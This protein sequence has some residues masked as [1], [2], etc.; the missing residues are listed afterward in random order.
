VEINSAQPVLSEIISNDQEKTKIELRRKKV[1]QASQK[2]MF[3]REKKS[4]F[5]T[6]VVAGI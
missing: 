4:K 1:T 5:V 6:S 2:N 3:S